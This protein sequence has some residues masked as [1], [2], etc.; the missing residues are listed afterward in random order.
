MGQFIKAVA[1]LQHVFDQDRLAV[2]VAVII[3]AIL[4]VYTSIDK[5]L[6]RKQVKIRKL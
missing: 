6:E 2:M 3:K 1:L 4:V 5:L